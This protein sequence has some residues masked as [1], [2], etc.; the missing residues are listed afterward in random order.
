ML[1]RKPRLA[2]SNNVSESQFVA[3]IPGGGTLCQKGE[4]VP[5]DAAKLQLA[6]GTYDL[7]RPQLS[8]NVE[9]PEGLV[10]RGTLSG[11]SRQGSIRIPITGP[12]TELTGARVCVRN[13][14]KRRVSLAGEP[15]RPVSVAAGKPQRGRIRLA[16]Y[17]SGEESWLELAPVVVR[18]FGLGKAP[19]LG[20]WTLWLAAGA[21]LASC[22]LAVAAMARGSRY[23]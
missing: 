15:V 11:G 8:V 22:V 3:D 12:R 1:E 21:A 6:V 9:S 20:S 19:W 13:D 10:S 18:R 14:G 7:P 2:G 5:H 17:R 23:R 16:W 4:L